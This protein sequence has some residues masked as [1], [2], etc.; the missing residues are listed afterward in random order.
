MA[1]SSIFDSTTIYNAGLY[2][3]ATGGCLFHKGNRQ[4]EKGEFYEI[5]DL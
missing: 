4:Y 3:K 2:E 5:N 1:R